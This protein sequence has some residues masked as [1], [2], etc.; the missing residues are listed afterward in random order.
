KSTWS[1]T[2]KEIHEVPPD[3]E[4]SLE[5]GLSFFKDDEDREKITLAVQQLTGKG[6]PYD[7]EVRLTTAK[8]NELWVRLIGRAEFEQGVCKRIYGAIYDIDAMKRAT[9]KIKNQQEILIKHSEKL[10]QANATKDKLFS[11]IGHDLR[12]PINTLVN[13]LDVISKG[14]IS[15]EEFQQLLPKVHQ[16]VKTVHHTLENLLQWSYSQMQGIKSAPKQVE[17]HDII[18]ENIALFTE[19]A[20]N[21]EIQLLYD[22]PPDFVVFADENQVRLIIRNLMNNAIK[23]T[24]KAGTVCVFAQRN[25]NSIGLCCNVYL[26]MRCIFFSFQKF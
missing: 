19:A 26:P 2:T 25:D 3:F 6:T 15:I 21:K 10:A 23:F 11:I 9:E 8:G 24:K 16:N 1:R 22:V 17:L 5:K 18:L 20:Q 12:S 14:F 4:P 13:L 7:I